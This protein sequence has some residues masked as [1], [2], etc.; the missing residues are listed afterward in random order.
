MLLEKQRSE[1][2]TAIKDILDTKPNLKAIWDVMKADA[3]YKETKLADLP[4]E[5]VKNCYIKLTE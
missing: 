1:Y 3:G 2:I 4:L 5:V